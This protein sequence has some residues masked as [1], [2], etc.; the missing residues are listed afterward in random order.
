MVIVIIMRGYA[1]VVPSAYSSTS[2]RPTAELYVPE[3]SFL[4]SYYHTLLL[5]NNNTKIM[6]VLFFITF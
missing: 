4:T 5:S 1:L 2:S 3:Q 6:C